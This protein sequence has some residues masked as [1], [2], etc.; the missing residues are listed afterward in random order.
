MNADEPINNSMENVQCPECGKDINVGI[1]QCPNCGYQLKKKK[2]G[3]IVVNLT[4]VILA[5]G[6]FIGLVIP[7]NKE[8][9]GL[10]IKDKRNA[11]DFIENLP[12]DCTIIDVFA[13]S[14]IHKV[15]YYKNTNDELEIR[16][17]DILTSEDSRIDY[18]EHFS[19]ISNYCYDKNKR[20][21]F[22]IAKTTSDKPSY[23]YSLLYINVDDCKSEIFAHGIAIYFQNKEEIAIEKAVGRDIEF[24]VPCDNFDDI[25]QFKNEYLSD[26]NNWDL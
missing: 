14:A 20:C 18:P 10:S 7:W 16:S 8:N 21:I 26:D 17:F 9:E 12:S 24:Y 3:A 5:V 22:V 23:R 19:A 13:D 4:L 15:F 6:L 11:I 2:W 1:L 25:L